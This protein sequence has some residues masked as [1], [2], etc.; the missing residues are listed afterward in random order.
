V[1]PRA[2][3]DVGIAAA[4]AISGGKKFALYCGSAHPPNIKGFFD[5]FGQGL[6]CLAPD[7]RLV[8]AGSVGE[9]IQNDVRFGRAPNVRH[10]CIIADLV[11]E[12]CLQGLLSTAHMIILPI[13]DG[14]GTKWLG[15]E[16]KKHT[17]QEKE[18]MV[19]FVARYK[20]GGKAHRLHEKSR[21]V[22]FDGKWFYV[23]GIYE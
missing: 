1:R 9:H 5:L 18:A 6:G 20:I 17:A 13:T 12:A 23:D 19:E 21:F 7:E 15:L 4:N 22:K 11:S 8:I 10:Q 2:V 16:V 3:T 14:G